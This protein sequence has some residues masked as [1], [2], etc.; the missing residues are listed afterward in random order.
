[1]LTTEAEDLLLQIVGSD[2]FQYDPE[3][4]EAHLLDVFGLIRSTGPDPGPTTT[5]RIV[6][7]YVRRA[8]SLER[9]Q[10]IMNQV[11]EETAVELEKRR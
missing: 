7:N 5:G 4:D 9:E 8:R 2:V 3:S 10:E 1:M 6:A 11:L